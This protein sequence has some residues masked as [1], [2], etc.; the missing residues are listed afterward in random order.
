MEHDRKQHKDEPAPL[1]PT[2]RRAMRADMVRFLDLHE[3]AVHDAPVPTPWYARF[4]A[5]ALTPS[6]AMVGV[7]V[8]CTFTLGASEFSLPNEPLHAV[9]TGFNERI[10]L[11]TTAFSPT[12][13]AKA[14]HTVLA[15]RLDEAEELMMRK[16]FD[17]HTADAL[18]TSIE[19]YETNL[20]ATLSRV[21][22]AEGPERAATIRT[23]QETML[24]RYD[25]VLD[26]IALRTRVGDPATVDILIEDA[27]ARY[28]GT[29]REELSE[30]EIASI[31]FAVMDHYADTLLREV[32]AIHKEITAVT[33]RTTPETLITDEVRR[34]LAA[35]N[36]ALDE[37]EAHLRNDDPEA[38]IAALH[39]A[40]V[41]ARDGLEL[42]AE[43][44]RRTTERTRS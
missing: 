31:E 21:E 12:L 20:A 11:A 13:Y 16:E 29:L 33:K 2:E 15:R 10:L 30:Q 37:A 42:M 17:S 36:A 40:H 22:Q 28:G 38:A 9:K 7:M 26:L 8:A 14:N 35:S 23:E 1:T 27:V 6:Y 34:A 43:E 24:A 39:D 32:E 44:L 4:G 19:R 18:Q 3:P 5:G 25:A 41:A